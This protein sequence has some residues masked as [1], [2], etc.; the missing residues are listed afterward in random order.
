MK[1]GLLD[2]LSR[3]LKLSIKICFRIH[4]VKFGKEQCKVF[5]PL[6]RCIICIA[7]LHSRHIL[8]QIHETSEM[9]KRLSWIAQQFACRFSIFCQSFSYRYENLS[10]SLIIFLFSCTGKLS[11]YNEFSWNILNYILKVRLID[12][13]TFDTVGQGEN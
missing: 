10:P 4:H 5:N 3:M 7:S 12:F 2:T 9:S 1:N 8:S 6:I 13:E 11:N